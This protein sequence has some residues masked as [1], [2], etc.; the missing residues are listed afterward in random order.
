MML[1]V[2]TIILA[3]FVLVCTLAMS[4]CVP[5]V[6]VIAFGAGAATVAVTS[7]EKDPAT[8]AADRAIADA[9]GKGYRRADRAIYKS[10]TIEVNQ[11]SVLLL[12]NVELPDHAI[13]AVQIAWQVDG[14]AE[15]IDEINVTDKSS[16]KDA[17]KDFTTKAQLRAKLVADPKIA[18]LNYSIN[19]I[20]GV[21]YLS[22]LAGSQ[23]E[24]NRVIAHAQAMRYANSVVNYIRLNN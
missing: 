4:A 10:V 20:N 6:P 24:I 18:S 14:V 16:I 13:R 15:V 1:R 22:G 17:A 11:G 12:G 3:V 8:A 7:K 5:A 9:I 2:P 21:V 23:S 19:V